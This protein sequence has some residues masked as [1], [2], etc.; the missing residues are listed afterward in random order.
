MVKIFSPSIKILL[1][2]IVLLIFVLL[3]IILS[4]KYI[5]P[6]QDKKIGEIKGLFDQLSEDMQ[7]VESKQLSN[8]KYVAVLRHKM[9]DGMGIAILNENYN[10]IEWLPEGE[11]LGPREGDKYPG[12]H[13]DW[14]TLDDI[15][16]DGFQ[17]LA[18]QFAMIGSAGSHPFYLYQYKNNDFNLLFKFIEGNSNVE[19]KDIDN[20]SNERIIYSFTLGSI[21]ILEKTNTPWKEVWTWQDGEYQLANHLFP[22]IYQDMIPMYNDLI[23]NVKQNN[24][25][26][27]YQKVLFCLKEKAELNSQGIFANGRECSSLI[28]GFE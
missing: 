21:G 24:V 28:P 7:I 1:I 17:E 27:S 6:C 19:L 3:N 13:L 18:I 23:E 12:E 5:N 20:N 9:F 16:N 15:N 10:I 14:W 2:F 11:Y 8:D 25:A 22:K 4:I 26:Q